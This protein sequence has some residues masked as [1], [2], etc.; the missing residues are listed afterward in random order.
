MGQFLSQIFGTGAGSGGSAA[1]SVPGSSS[2]QDDYF[3][4]QTALNN[5][6]FQTNAAP[7]LI[8]SQINNNLAANPAPMGVMSLNPAMPGSYN[9][10]QD[11]ALQSLY[12][13]QANAKQAVSGW[14][15]PTY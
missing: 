6:R 4:S 10:T 11:A 3:R 5:Q 1:S 2:A 7:G 13:Q 8:Q 14:T 15:A 12:G 9:G